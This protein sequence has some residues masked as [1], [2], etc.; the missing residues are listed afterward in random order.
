MNVKE[1]YSQDAQTQN[2]RKRPAPA[3][4]VE[5]E[6]AMMDGLMPAAAAMKRRR[7]EEQK[8]AERTGKSFDNSFK[9]PQPREPTAAKAPKKEVNIKDAVRERRQA[10]DQAAR[11][12]EESLRTT[13]DDIDIEAMKSLA[14]VEEMKIPA[15][16][17]RRNHYATNSTSGD[18][19]DDRWN[20]RKNFKKY[21][22]QGETTQDRRG[23][24]VIVPLEQV[25]HKD[26]GIGEEYWLE[27]SDKTRKKRKD[28]TQSQSQAFS[29][30]RSQQA[31]EVDL[32][33]DEPSELEVPAELLLHNGD[34]NTPE[35]INVEAPRITRGMDHMQQTG[36]S[37]TRSQAAATGSKR[38]APA[39][40]TAPAP[41]KRKTI[42]VKDSDDSDSGDELKFRFR[43]RR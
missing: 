42:A 37:S 21:R 11:Q 41:K 6:E 39:K 33:P 29:S 15:R 9:K 25:K 28:K 30:A 4:E 10:E 34:D 16:S 38:K 8:E 3:P 35:V 27:N 5:D 1:S 22:R 13:V 19:W 31:E 7:I 17:D 20:G 24:S 36:Q 43:K 2:P 12:N 14:V 32:V 26:F 23:L 18:R 40:E